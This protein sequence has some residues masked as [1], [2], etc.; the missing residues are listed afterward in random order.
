MAIPPT[1]I[2]SWNNTC[3]EDHH[4]LFHLRSIC[5]YCPQK[6]PRLFECNLSF[7]KGRWLM[8]IGA[9][10]NKRLKIFKCHR[11]CIPKHKRG[12]YSLTFMVTF[13]SF[14]ENIKIPWLRS[15]KN[16]VHILGSLGL[17][18]LLAY[19]TLRAPITCNLSYCMISGILYI[20]I[21]HF[22]LIFL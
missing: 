9:L 1:G 20:C 17:E 16:L 19:I 21:M 5:P 22:I 4:T 11:M 13:V 3:V 6:A 15:Q 18:F 7:H 12:I 2:F 10:R 8:L 14:G